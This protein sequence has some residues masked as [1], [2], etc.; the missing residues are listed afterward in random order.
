MLRRAQ[1]LAQYCF[2]CG[3]LLLYLVQYFWAISWFLLEYFGD[4]IE[5]ELEELQFRGRPAG[6]EVR[7]LFFPILKVLLVGLTTAGAAHAHPGAPFN[8][9]P[10]TVHYMNINPG[11]GEY[12]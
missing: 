4:L 5:F 11:D 12:Q 8:Q 9:D 10:A 7:N 1:E 3:R 2:E 6:L